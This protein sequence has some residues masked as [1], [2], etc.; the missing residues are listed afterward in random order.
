MSVA[1]VVGPCGSA[2]SFKVALEWLW[3][4]PKLE[5]KTMTFRM[6]MLSSDVNVV[7]KEFTRSPGLFS[8]SLEDAF[9]ILLCL[10]SL[11]LI[12]QGHLTVIKRV[13]NSP[14]VPE[15]CGEEQS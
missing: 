11:S 14:E 9:V 6:G 12:H 1:Y 15:S 13:G 3:F 7:A 5:K 4:W 2:V 8:S 10:L